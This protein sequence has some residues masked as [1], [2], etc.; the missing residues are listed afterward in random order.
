MPCLVAARHG[1]NS[2]L[3]HQRLALRPLAESE[4]YEEQEG[5]TLT[6][7]A[8]CPK[9]A[10][11]LFGTPLPTQASQ[12]FFIHT[13]PRH[14]QSFPLIIPLAPFE[15][16]FAHLRFRPLF[17]VVHHSP[18]HTLVRLLPCLIATY[19]A[20]G[21]FRRA[22]GALTAVSLLTQ[23]A[24]VAEAV[25][26]DLTQ[27]CTPF[28]AVLAITGHRKSSLTCAIKLIIYPHSIHQSCR[29]DDRG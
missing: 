29:P 7:S 5:N 3:Q 24:F 14:T 15:I 13:R 21:F 22:V 20:M 17:S 16:L 1:S 25:E 8:D 4:R 9:T 23:N 2:K 12:A 27:P 10:L 11:L 26:L 28:A 18:P 6:G 19:G